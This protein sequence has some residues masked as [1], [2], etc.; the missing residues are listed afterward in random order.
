[1]WPLLQYVILIFFSQNSVW[2]LITW[3][4]GKGW[5]GL[6]RSYLAL[7]GVLIKSMFRCLSC[8]A[9]AKL[10]LLPKWYRLQTGFKKKLIDTVKFSSNGV[11]F[12]QRKK[13]FCSEP[14]LMSKL[15]W[16]PINILVYSFAVIRFFGYRLQYDILWPEF[17]E[18]LNFDVIVFIVYLR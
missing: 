11:K 14:S 15:R 6:F 4:L 17:T 10:L 12:S 13:N 3:E 8:Q 16:S 9:K 1:M 18:R 7:C 2:I 5:A